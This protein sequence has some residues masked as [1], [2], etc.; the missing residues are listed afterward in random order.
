MCWKE[1]LFSRDP[2]DFYGEDGHDEKRQREGVDT[3]VP[4]R[5]E[6]CKAC[7]LYVGV[8]PTGALALKGGTPVVARS[9]ACDYSGLCDLICPRLA[10]QRPYGV[11][12]LEI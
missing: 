8:C 9:G 3:R 1:E 7:E 10:I 5:F 2:S 6:L 12:D 11:A 4:H